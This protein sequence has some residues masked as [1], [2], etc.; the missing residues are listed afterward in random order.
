MAPIYSS[1][2]EIEETAPSPLGEVF[3]PRAK[4]DDLL[5][6]AVIKGHPEIVP[7]D[8]GRGAVFEQHLDYGSHLPSFPFLTVVYS[9][10]KEHRR[11]SHPTHTY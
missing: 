6:P 5:D 9:V 1:E 4:V 10:A 8:R 2:Q 11:D 3:P 7:T